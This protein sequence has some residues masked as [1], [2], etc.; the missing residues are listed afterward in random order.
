VIASVRQHNVFLAAAICLPLIAIHYLGWLDLGNFVF[1]P[2][3]TLFT[4]LL[5]ALADKSSEKN[6]PTNG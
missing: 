1:V 6:G 3:L 4:I 5:A 2:I